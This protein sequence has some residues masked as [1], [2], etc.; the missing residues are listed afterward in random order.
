MKPS[1][2]YNRIEAILLSRKLPEN[3]PSLYVIDRESVNDPHHGHNFDHA[4]NEE[5]K[6]PPDEQ[7]RS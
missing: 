1:E 4:E 5:G 2:L 7:F 3:L 6:K